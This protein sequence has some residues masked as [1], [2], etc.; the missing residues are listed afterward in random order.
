MELK[1]SGNQRPFEHMFLIEWLLNF[2]TYIYIHFV[3]HVSERSLIKTLVKF[4]IVKYIPPLMT[5]SQNQCFYV[6]KISLLY[7]FLKWN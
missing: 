2:N 3:L 5:C 4:M 1:V 7:F 6:E